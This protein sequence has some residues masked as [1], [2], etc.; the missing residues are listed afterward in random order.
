[1]NSLKILHINKNDSGG[2]AAVAALRIHRA[3]RAV[4]AESKLLV[5]TKRSEDAH[6]YALGKGTFHTLKCHYH[7]IAERLN[8]LKDEKDVTLRYAFSPAST[9]F[10]I[11]QHPL[12]LE[13][14][15]IH[16][17]WI[18]QGFLS[19]ASL[20]K[21]F[22]LKKPIVWT[23]HDMWPFTGGCHY[24]GSCMEYNEHC[25]YC[26]FLRKPAKKDLS[27]RIFL[28]KK[29]IYSNTGLTAVA[30][31]KWL[32]SLS[33]ES[34]LFQNLNVAS[35]PNAIDTCQFRPLDKTLCREA[36]KLPTDKKLVLFGAANLLDVR[37][38]FRYLI[39]ALNIIK[40]N[41]PTLS[42]KI[43]LVVFGKLKDDI[44]KQIPFEIHNMKFITDTEK[45][46]MIY[47]SADAFLLPSLQDNLPNTV[48]ESMACQTP[49]VGFRIG[50]V[51]EMVVHEKTGFLAEARNSLSLATGLYQTLFLNDATQMGLAAR[52]RVVELYS[53][54]VV[55]QQYLNIYLNANKPQK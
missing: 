47:N 12:V 22:K 9:G 55:A 52:D 43:E 20:D 45:L 49:V 8:F 48:M 2:G 51:P 19:L 17:H 26:P 38:G 35:I 3:L 39:E 40:E 15:I 32:R 16:L 36:L 6:T 24:A 44:C 4:G 23:L 54:K 7:F 37:K 41:F 14:D 53:E 50:G 13:A 28:R 30:C 29:K 46:V 33:S 18:N 11:S 5:L 21:L 25:G 34:S 42:S 27:N 10:D 1:M 31:S